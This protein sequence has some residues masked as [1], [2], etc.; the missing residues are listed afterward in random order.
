ME[1]NQHGHIA[2]WR[3]MPGMREQRECM[4]ITD[5][6]TQDRGLWYPDAEYHLRHHDAHLP[7][8]LSAHVLG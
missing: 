2:K 8:Y 3:V 1:A 5:R 7:Y 6:N 4:T